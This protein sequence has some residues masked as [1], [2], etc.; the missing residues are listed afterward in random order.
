M[1]PVF[2]MRLLSRRFVVLACLEANEL[3]ARE[4]EQLFRSKGCWGS[5]CGRSTPP[6]S[7]SASTAR[8]T[9]RQLAH[10]VEAGAIRAAGEGA[11]QLEAR[12]LFR[13]PSRVTTDDPRPT[14]DEQTRRF[15]AK[16]TRATPEQCDWNVTEAT[17]ALGPRTDACLQPHQSIRIDPAL[18]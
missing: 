13:E 15:Q 16:L 17:R 11:V 8:P 18:M 6:S 2:R 1:G 12:L 9:R 7:R 10:T 14:F 3:L 4:S 5:S